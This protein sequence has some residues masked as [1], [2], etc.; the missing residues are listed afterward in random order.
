[1]KILLDSCVWGKARHELETAGHDVVWSGDWPSDPGD[2]EILARAHDEDRVLVTLDKDF[3]ELAVLRGQPHSGILRLV[4]ISARQQARVCLQVLFKHE[5][6]LA[7]GAII[8]AEL[9][10]L[11]IRLP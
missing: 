8:T 7:S 4:G 10:R 3:G 6:E 5:A 2:E 9:G 1:M 11:R